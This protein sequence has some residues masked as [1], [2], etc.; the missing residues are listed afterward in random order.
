MRTAIVLTAR[1]TNGR[2]VSTWPRGVIYLLPARDIPIQRRFLRAAHIL[3]G[4][5]GAHLYRRRIANVRRLQAA[6][7][8]SGLDGWMGLDVRISN[9]RTLPVEI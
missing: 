7:R 6:R 1:R 8:T 3:D 4:V 5:I 9:G 2:G